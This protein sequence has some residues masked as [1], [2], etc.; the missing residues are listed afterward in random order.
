MG[1]LCALL[2]GG[3]PLAGAQDAQ[4]TAPTTQATGQGQAATEATNPEPGT[5]GRFNPSGTAQAQPQPGEAG[6]AP[7]GGTETDPQPGTAGRFK[8][9]S[10]TVDC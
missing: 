7:A 1:V 5:E 4:G 10:C 3:V 9:E 2:A 6:T 8:P